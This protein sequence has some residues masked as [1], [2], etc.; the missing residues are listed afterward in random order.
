MAKRKKHPKLPNSFGSIRSLGGKRHNQYAVHPPSTEIDEEGR[1]IRPKALCYVPDWYTGFAVLSAYHAGTYHPGDEVKYQAT[2]EK[3]LQTDANLD[4]F[5]NMLLKNFATFASGE[6]KEDQGPTFKEVYEQFFEWKYGEHASKKLSKSSRDA[7]IF[8]YGNC[9]PLY[10]KP[11]KSITLDEMQNMVNDCQLKFSSVSC[12]VSLLKQ[13]GKFALPRKYCIENYAA[14]LVIPDCEGNEHGVPFSDKDMEK[15]WENS[16][17][18]IIEMVLIM[19]YS[20]FRISAFI[21]L[22]VN[23]DEW[24]FKGGVKTKSSKDRIVPIH[25]AIRPLVVRRIERYGKLLNS[26]TGHFRQEMYLAL[27]K[28]NIERHTPH[29]CRHTFSGLCERYKVNENDRIRLMGHSFG[30]D[31][32]NGIYGHRT[33]E[34]LRTE[35]EKIKVPFVVNCV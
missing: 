26:S 10:D 17:D 1:R 3:T 22:E 14:Y 20:G 21:T 24:Y 25:S 18:P 27:E 8:A 31:I 34:E 6:E 13:L 2:R 23:M 16:D 4:T 19:C 15:L 28:Y 5:C 35:I 30:S 11:Y 32:T 7:A 12:L 33:V 9:K 29:D